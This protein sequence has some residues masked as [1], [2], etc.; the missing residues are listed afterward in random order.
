MVGNDSGLEEWRALV[1]QIQ[2][3]EFPNNHMSLE[4]E[5]KLQKRT[6]SHRDLDSSLAGM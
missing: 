6:Q 4:K 3:T 5:S 1:L 2:G